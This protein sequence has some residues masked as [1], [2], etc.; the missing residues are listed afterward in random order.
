LENLEENKEIKMETLSGEAFEFSTSI[1][2]PVDGCGFLFFIHDMI[3]RRQTSSVFV[4]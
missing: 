2:R 1:H 3:R 4:G